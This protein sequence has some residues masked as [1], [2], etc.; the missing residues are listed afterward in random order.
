[1][2]YHNGNLCQSEK[3]RRTFLSAS[4][5]VLVG[6]LPDVHLIG[7]QCISP[8]GW[9]GLLLWPCLAWRILQPFFISVALPMK[10]LPRKFLPGFYWWTRSRYR[11]FSAAFLVR[12][13]LQHQTLI[14][15]CCTILSVTICITYFALEL[16]VKRRICLKWYLKGKNKKVWV[17]PPTLM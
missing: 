12:L 14:H 6:F 9:A 1:M 7:P 4:T 17:F 3:T 15:I 11:T 8:S 16:C 2:W 5:K 10:R 13:S